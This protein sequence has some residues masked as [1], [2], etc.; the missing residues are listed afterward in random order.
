M[1]TRTERRYRR[2]L[3]AYPRSYRDHRGAEILT[4]LLEMAEDGRKPGVHLVLAGLRQRFR[5]PARRPLAWVAALR[6]EVPELPADGPHFA[7]V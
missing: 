2:L 3:W 1:T 5:L 4:T 7:E 6:G